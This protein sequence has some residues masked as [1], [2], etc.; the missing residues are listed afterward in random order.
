MQVGH[1]GAVTVGAGRSRVIVPITPATEAEAITQAAHATL[2][3]ADV[4]EWRVDSLADTSIEHACHIA[5]LLTT[6][7][8][9]PL[10]ATFRTAAEGG[11]PIESRSYEQLLHSLIASGSIDAVDVEFFHESGP[12]TVRKIMSYARDGGIP[13]IASHHDFS[14]TPSA[15]KIVHILTQMADSGANIAKIATMPRT[16]ADVA[17]L[18]SATWEAS[19]EVEIPVITMAMG[20]L[21]SLSRAA[22][23]LFGSAAT[24]AMVDHASAPGQV[25]ITELVPVMRS[26][27]RWSEVPGA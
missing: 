11:A 15:E 24:F 4:V 10:L 22:G 3:G 6:R 19:T 8:A 16:P 25:P 26:L 7:I 17:T 9:Q 13:V 18:L 14:A 5:A 1:I 21:G 20:P 2:S 12:A 23:G 27:E